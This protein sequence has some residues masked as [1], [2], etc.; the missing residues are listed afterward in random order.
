MSKLKFTPEGEV[1]QIGD[2]WY[3]PWAKPYEEEEGSE[4]YCHGC[5]L[6]GTKGCGLQACTAIDRD[7]LT[8]VVFLYVPIN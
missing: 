7:D 3:T 1:F 8:E 2:K 4:P 5:S 6:F